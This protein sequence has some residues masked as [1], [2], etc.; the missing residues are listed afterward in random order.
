M[1]RHDAGA[2]PAGEAPEDTAEEIDLSEVSAEQLRDRLSARSDGRDDQVVEAA[3]EL[4]ASLD[5]LG[6]GLAARRAALVGRAGGGIARAA[7]PYVGSVVATGVGAVLVVRR[8]RRPR[9]SR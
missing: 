3:R 1:G 8:V 6:E 5:R 9:R 7:V 2:G 4:R